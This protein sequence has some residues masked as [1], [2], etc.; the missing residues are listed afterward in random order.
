MYEP[1]LARHARD[2]VEAQFAAA[3]QPRGPAQSSHAPE[4]RRAAT[5][6]PLRAASARALRAVA[7]RLEPRPEPRS[8]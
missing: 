5:A 1:I 8:A 3:E 2:R 4:A 7:D 6:R